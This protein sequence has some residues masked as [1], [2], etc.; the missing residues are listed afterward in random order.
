MGVGGKGW[1]TGN[2]GQSVT[3]SLVARASGKGSVHMPD[4]AHVLER[5][6]GGGSE[7]GVRTLQVQASAGS[8]LWKARP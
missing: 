5:R 6:G 2:G 7:V 8:H 3:S 4:I 1:N